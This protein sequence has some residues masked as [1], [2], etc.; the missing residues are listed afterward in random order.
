[1]VHL[2]RAHCTGAQALFQPPIRAR[3]SIVLPEMLRPGAHDE[4]LDMAFGILEVAVDT[5][6]R[7][8]AAPPYT[9]GLQHR[10]PE[11]VRMAAIDDVLDGHQ[12]RAG[13]PEST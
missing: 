1:M 3:Q 2:R 4:R 12:H 8:P 5:P 11:R 6:A 7:R 10:G 9:L 13:R